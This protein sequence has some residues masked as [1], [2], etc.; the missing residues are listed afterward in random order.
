[1]NV[2][3]SSGLLGKVLRNLSSESFAIYQYMYPKI[4]RSLKHTRLL[5]QDITVREAVETAS[6]EYES[7]SRNAIA[8]K[9]DE[10]KK[11]WKMR[12]ELLLSQITQ[13]IS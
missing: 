13:Q 7:L 2:D 12:M 5:F 10:Q 6:Y 1:M 3:E 8:A 9:I 4:D 11:D